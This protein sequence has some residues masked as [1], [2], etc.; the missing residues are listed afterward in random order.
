MFYWKQSLNLNWVLW[1]YNQI[2]QVSLAIAKSNIFEQQGL[3]S[4]A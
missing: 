3:D 4:S 2:I 1:K